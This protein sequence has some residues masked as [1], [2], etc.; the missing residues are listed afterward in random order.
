MGYPVTLVDTAGLRESSDP[1]EQEGIRRAHA[2]VEEADLVL[3]L[4]D[5]TAPAAAVQAHDNQLILINKI[6]IKGLKNEM[7]FNFEDIFSIEFISKAGHLTL[8]FISM[9]NKIM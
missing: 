5:A 2:R 9:K 3:W 4:V 8:R 1:V 6:D 7:E